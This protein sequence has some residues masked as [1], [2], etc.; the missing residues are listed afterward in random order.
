MNTDGRVLTGSWRGELYVW[1]HD[2]CKLFK[3]FDA[4]AGPLQSVSI[5][6][7][8]TAGAGFATGGAD[9]AVILWGVDYIKWRRIDL[10][11]LCKR[12]PLDVCGRPCLLPPTRGVHVRAV[13]WDVSE[14]RVLVGTES[15]EVR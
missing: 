10:N 13:C 2:G 5:N 8:Q 14:R 6:A 4:H 1:Q 7:D 15:N 12:S 9:G 11:L 3:R